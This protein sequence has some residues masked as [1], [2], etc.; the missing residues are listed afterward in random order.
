MSMQEAIEGLTG[1]VGTVDVSRTTLV[2]GGD[3]RENWKGYQY[4]ITFIGSPGDR[5][6]LSVVDRKFNVV[7]DTMVEVETA[8]HGVKNEFYNYKGTFTKNS[9][10]YV[11]ELFPFWVMIFDDTM[12]APELL[13]GGFDEAFKHAVWSQEVS[14]RT[15]E[16]GRVI[17]LAPNVKGSLVRVML[18]NG[19]YLSLA[20]VQVFE[21]RLNTMNQL[22]EG[23]PIAERPLTQPYSGEDSLDD[24]FKNIQFGGAWHLNIRDLT[25]Y[26]NTRGVGGEG[27]GGGED[28]TCGNPGSVEGEGGCKGLMGEK[29]GV[30]KLNDWILM[31]T[32]HAG[33]VHRYYSDQL[34]SILTLPKYGELFLTEMSEKDEGYRGYNGRGA[35]EGRGRVEEA[36]GMGRKLSPCYGVDTTGLNGVDSVGSH[37]YCP[38][39]FG[40]GGLMNTQKGGAMSKTTLLGKERVVVYRPFRDF[41]GV[42]HFTYQ[43]WDGVDKGEVTEVRIEVKNCRRF[44]RAVTKGDVGVQGLCSCRRTEAELF[45]GAGC[46]AAVQATCGL[47]T[48]SFE[49]HPVMCSMCDW[50]GLQ[51]FTGV[52]QHSSGCKVEIEKAVALM[53]SK[54]MC[55]AEVPKEGYPSCREESTTANAREPYILYGVGTEY[56]RGGRGVTK[57]H[58]P[59]NSIK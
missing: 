20:E 3:W 55:D 35:D 6:E 48:S 23:S 40:V 57:V 29:N 30:G 42:D 41:L 33:V 56:F 38:L 10:A 17:N 4:S 7:N 15:G 12:K 50:A 44:E 31:I 54:G 58:M 13:Q 21:S 8:R 28:G 32:D 49:E 22:V 46:V 24:K 27:A 53:E 47:S 19:N 18:K 34:S 43:P 14:G 59:L 45:G 25:K 9:V 51:G 39:N 16:E 2:G 5:M 52:A 11:E 37:R 1:L 26:S 36:E